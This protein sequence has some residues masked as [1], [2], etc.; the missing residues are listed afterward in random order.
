ME[1][2]TDGY[3]LIISPPL[4]KDS[5]AV[6]EQPHYLTPLHQA[7][8]ES[9]MDPASGDTLQTKSFQIASGELLASASGKGQPTEA[10][11]ASLDIIAWRVFADARTE[12]PAGLA[13]QKGLQGKLKIVIADP[14]LAWQVQDTLQALRK[15]GLDKIELERTAN[16]QNSTA[17]TEALVDR[18]KED[19]P[20]KILQAL[21]SYDNAPL[22]ERA[23]NNQERQRVE[24]ELQE[25][26]RRKGLAPGQLRAHPGLLREHQQVRNRAEDQTLPQT[27]GTQADADQKARQ[28]VI[29]AARRGLRI[30]G[31]A[32][33]Q[34][35]DALDGLDQ[36]GAAELIASGLEWCLY[37]D[38][39]KKST[40][41][42]DA[43]K[44]F[45]RG[46]LAKK[47]SLATLCDG[48]AKT[49]A[50]GLFND[51]ASI[52]SRDIVDNGFAHI[53]FLFG[54]TLPKGPLMDSSRTAPPPI[55][56]KASAQYMSP[57]TYLQMSQ[58]VVGNVR[59]RWTP[60][61][62]SRLLTPVD[63]MSAHASSPETDEGRDDFISLRWKHSVP[64]QLAGYSLEKTLADG[65]HSYSRHIGHDPHETPPQEA[66]ELQPKATRN[67]LQAM[68]LTGLADFIWQHRNIGLTIQNVGLAL[69]QA[70]SYYLPLP[71]ERQAMQEALE[72]RDFHR[73]IAG[74]FLL[75]QCTIADVVL[76]ETVKASGY[77][78]FQ[79]AGWI[80]PSM[81]GP[82]TDIQHVQ[83]GVVLG[84]GEYIFDATPSQNIPLPPQPAPRRFQRISA[85][86]GAR[87]K[88]AQ[89]EFGHADSEMQNTILQLEPRPLVVQEPDEVHIQE[90]E[91]VMLATQQKERTSVLGELERQIGSLYG[92]ADSKQLYLHIGKQ[93][94]RPQRAVSPLWR[95]LSLVRRVTA[96]RDVSFAE[97]QQEQRYLTA[98]LDSQSGKLRAGQRTAP[99]LATLL[100]GA[101]QSLHDT[102]P[103]DSQIAEK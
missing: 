91:Q 46:L 78:T 39:S 19:T 53:P 100:Q 79:P 70:S 38:P 6:R 21:C 56:R 32:N 34:I 24:N 66:M 84:P 4:D 98:V 58:E 60:S 64:P 47:D 42:M 41:N 69:E 95:T 45:M 71:D 61:S 93:V 18:V 82:V 101:L 29:Q 2:A 16:M 102:F 49:V 3:N 65:S 72:Q 76:A 90:A 103:P 99:Q 30:N 23:L 97:V 62:A 68:G 11:Q 67:A 77:E 96:G 55:I 88:K 89:P 17:L 31:Y 36:W 1:A 37:P 7:W 94:P 40:K 43:C 51:L 52:G 9:Q 81:P 87:P 8:A 48:W 26:L 13:Y 5:E 86:L 85:R 63:T 92:I 20:Y 80:L 25:D 22:E 10:L 35:D 44:E 28:K 14:E 50:G 83:T 12:L 33:E 73:L 15:E 74:G 57:V 59:G 27:T 54:D 75:S